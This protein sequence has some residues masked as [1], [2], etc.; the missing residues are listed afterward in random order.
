M[1]C[2]QHDASLLDHPHTGRGATM[3]GPG[4]LTHLDK[5]HR[6]VASLHDQ[7]D[8]ATA[9]PGRP[10]IALKQ[11]QARGL[12]MLQGPVFGRRPR[13]TGAAS[14]QLRQLLEESH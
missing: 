13:L 3:A 14:A 12:Q 10:I 2:S 7:I 5:D 8:L 4:T 6:A 9:A 1:A 11:A